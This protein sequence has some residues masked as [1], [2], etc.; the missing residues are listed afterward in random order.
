MRRSLSASEAVVRHRIAS[1]TALD[2]WLTARL[3]Q[4]IAASGVGV[5]LWDGTTIQSGGERIGDLLIRDR[6]ALAALLINPDLQYGELYSAG[7]I[8][9]RGDLAAVVD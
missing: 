5:E 7:R 9:V 8:D 3:Q 2:R 6:G 4:S 1:T